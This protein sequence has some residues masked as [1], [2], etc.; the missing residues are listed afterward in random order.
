MI[1]LG[2]VSWGSAP[3]IPISFA[4][5]KQ[6]SGADMKYRMQI[7]VSAVTGD[8]YYGYPIYFAWA[9]NGGEY[10]SVTVKEASP[11][12]WS[13]A[14]TYTTPWVTVSNKTSGTTSLSLRV[15]SGLGSSRNNYYSYSMG[16]DPAASKISA[17]NGTLGTALTINITRYNSAFKDTI[18]Y[19]CGSAAGTVVSGSTS[20]SATWNASTGNT[21]ALSAQ[22]TTGQSVNVTFTVSTYS[23]SSLVGTNDVT[24]SMAIPAS[25]QPTVT[26][27]VE[28]AAGY[29]DTYGAFVQGWSKLKFTATPELAYGSPIRSYSIVSEGVTYTTNPA[30]ATSAISS[31]SD[32]VVTFQVTDKR[33]RSSAVA[34]ATLQVLPYS[35]PTVNLTAERCTADGTVDP[36]GAY[37]VISLTASASSLGGKNKMRYTITYPGGTLDGTG[38]TSVATTS[39]PIACN[40][41]STHEVDV[42]VTDDLTSTSKSVTVPVA[43]TLRDF[44]SSGEGVAFGKVATRKGFDCAMNAYFTGSVSLGNGFTDGSDTGWV[45]LNNTVS[46]RRKCG[47]VT[48]VGNS[49]GDVT[50]TSG[51]YAVVGTLPSGYRPSIRIP[52]V[53]HT[54]G[55]SPVS[56]S[57][58]IETD[59]KIR[60]YTNVGGTSYW[61]FTITYP[62]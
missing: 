42:V 12:R 27:K 62:I 44:H 49:Q 17:S 53:F 58:F 56:Q 26:G 32:I 30:T 39:Q 60:L 61:A 54:V 55:G 25:V 19:K 24:V 31:K 34:R 4:Y 59:G 18:T 1:S 22:N 6:R 50:L 47:Y 13:S 57:G 45:A 3:T 10:T 23:G 36:E 43:F 15:Y 40:V 51:D 9:V 52:V 41:A 11:S 7:S 2:S 38:E 8:S 20:T 35:K 28:D 48:V 21:V 46:Y 5:E 16:V 37:M 29:Y 33:E 14:I